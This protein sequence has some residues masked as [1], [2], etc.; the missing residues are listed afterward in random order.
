[1]SAA[2]LAA[3][4]KRRRKRAADAYKRRLARDEHWLNIVRAEMLNPTHD[5]FSIRQT[6]EDN[7]ARWRAGRDPEAWRT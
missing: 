5:T 3:I 4:E 6:N 2:I 7:A 1:M